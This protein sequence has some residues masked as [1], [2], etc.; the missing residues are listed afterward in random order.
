MIIL[1]KTHRIRTR[2]HIGSVPRRLVTKGFT[3]IY[4]VD[5]KET[6][7]PM[8]KMNTIKIIL[9]MV[10]YFGREL[11]QFDDKNAFFNEHLKKEV[12]TKIPQD[13]RSIRKRNRVCKLRKTLYELMSSPF[14]WFGKLT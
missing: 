5:Y 12:Y 10:A 11:E 3:Q 13:F 4:G 7:T 9:S 1:V 14:V 6:I 8:T 2:W